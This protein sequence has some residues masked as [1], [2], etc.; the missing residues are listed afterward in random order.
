MF[1]PKYRLFIGNPGVGKSTL[2]NC[3]ANASLFKSGV[4]F[5]KG[6]T[7]KLDIKTHNGITYLD[8]PG[9]SDIQLREQAAKS[10]TEALKKDG[11]YQVFFVITLE[12]GRVRPEDMTTI[13][14][15]LESASDIKHYS[16]IINKLSTVA[17]DRLVEDNAEQLK[18]LVSELLEQIN[19]KN[20]PPTILL[21]R[22]Q[23]KLHDVENQFM[24]W[25]ELNE[26]VT[27]SPSIYVKP[28]CVTDLKGDPFSFQEAMDI[29]TCQIEELRSDNE[30][31]M[32]IQ[33]ETEE[34]YRKLMLQKQLQEKEPDNVGETST[35]PP[36]GEKV[37]NHFLFVIFALLALK[38]KL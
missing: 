5:G 3:V 28:A 9:L 26:F 2:A 29:F 19:S 30:R 27:K 21:L 14:L 38:C 12:A 7:Y 16:L 36:M 13:K 25:D 24:N 17:F 18:I 37:K 8:T 15:V 31:M 4:H 32:K 11:T 34:K 10:I 23:F 33:K 35:K 1:S 22:H 6:M 20:D